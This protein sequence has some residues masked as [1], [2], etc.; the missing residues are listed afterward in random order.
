VYIVT[1]VPPNPKLALLSQYPAAYPTTGPTA[2]LTATGPGGVNA[3]CVEAP[4]ERLTGIINVTAPGTGLC[5]GNGTVPPGTY[6]LTQVPA[7]GTI[8]SR[9]D[10]YN[11]TNGA[12]GAPIN[13]SSITLGLNMS[14]TCVAVYTLVPTQ[15]RLAL[16]SDFPPQYNGPTGNLT[17]IS[18]GE[19]CQ[20]FPSPRI[21]ATANVT[22]IY[23]NGGGCGSNATFGTSPAGNYTLGQVRFGWCCKRSWLLLHKTCS[24]PQQKLQLPESLHCWC[25]RQPASL[26]ACHLSTQITYSRLY[27]NRPRHTSL[28]SFP[29]SFNVHHGAAAAAAAAVDSSTWCVL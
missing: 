13:G 3:S 18:T 25:C 12:A 1:V 10:C 7:P 5:F 19:T 29:Y 2:N 23:P 6:N 17:A 8:F 20:K 24:Q 11:V 9:W 4:S 14:M 22:V 28:S 26:H 15:P 27:D 21:N 16:L